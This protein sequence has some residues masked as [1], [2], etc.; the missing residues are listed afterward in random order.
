[1]KDMGRKKVLIK[2]TGGGTKMLVLGIK[3]KEAMT[4]KNFAR[5]REIPCKGDH[6]GRGTSFPDRKRQ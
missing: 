3:E 1:M 4:P 2:C 6:T 5:K